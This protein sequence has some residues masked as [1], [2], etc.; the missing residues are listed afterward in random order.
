MSLRTRLLLA[1]GGALLA[2]FLAG[3]GLSAWQAARGVR[4]ELAAAQATGGQTI[5]GALQD[6]GGS[7]GREALLR[8]VA[9]FDGSRHVRA[10][11]LVGSRVIAQSRPAA[12]ANSPAWFMRLA[13]P[14]LTARAFPLGG[15][16]MLRLSPMPENEVGERWAEMHR[17]ILLLALF[18]V[19]SAVSSLAT[20]AIGLRPLGLLGDA[21]AELA[22]G[23]DPRAVPERGPTD[24]IALSAAFNRMQLALRLAGAENR[25]LSD[26]IATLAEEERAELAR[27]LHDEV[28]PLLFAITAWAAAARMQ[29]QGRDTTAATAS[30]DSLAAA[31]AQL[32]QAVRELLRRVRDSAAMPTDLAA[33]VG[34]L[35]A[36]W[37]GISPQTSF[38][39]EIPPAAEAA[40]EPAKAALFRVAQESI[41]NAVRHGAPSCVHVAVEC[42]DQGVTLRVEDDGAG[43]APRH[44]AN[45]GF[46]LAGMEERL[47]AL[48]GTL[49]ITR[50]RGW[51]VT[52]WAP[53]QP[54]ARP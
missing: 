5:Q 11:L 7:P 26:Q 31:A 33:S 27:D 51:R 53:A 21:F 8:L 20:V 38:S 2:S 46:G 15:G 23:A 6:M 32:Q 25:R 54:P 22:Q 4:V 36:F 34:E 28:G 47:R 39:L 30:L 29:A 41:S 40:P 3:A 1:I 42:R 43:A 24:I 44:A 50:A 18:S 37:R 49:E 48:G 9:S 19:L 17:L 12:A 16:A 45:D 14:L 35:L 52:A 13:S 10:E